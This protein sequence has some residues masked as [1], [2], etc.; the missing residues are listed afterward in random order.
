MRF[1]YTFVAVVVLAGALLLLGAGD[2]PS[3]EER[4]ANPPCEPLYDHMMGL[5]QQ[6]E[7]FAQAWGEM[8]AEEEAQKRTEFVAMCGQV[9]NPGGIAIS[10]CIM[11]ATTFEGLEACL[12]SKREVIG[13]RLMR[14]DALANLD[15][16]RTAEKAYNA[17][18]DGYLE[19]PWTPAEIPSAAVDFE[20]PGRAAFDSMGWRPMGQV[21]CRYQ[22]T[23]SPPGMESATPTF[24]AN[25]ECDLDGD[26][27][28]MVLRSTDATKAERITHVDVY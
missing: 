23:V 15:A 9:T 10:W 11:D 12:E 19:C 1:R 21:V 2:P 22:V 3:S 13:R 4:T 25:A 27:T 6:N 20:G 7:A 14:G 26:G 28:P 8:T 24:E 5:F 16:I 18:F 17:S